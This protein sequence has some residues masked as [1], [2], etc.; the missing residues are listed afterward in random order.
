VA[1]LDEQEKLLR[2][3][4]DPFLAALGAFI[5]D[6]TQSKGDES[7]E[8]MASAKE[9]I[10][11]GYVISAYARPELALRSVHVSS[12]LTLAIAPGSG[13]TERRKAFEAAANDLHEWPN[14][15]LKEVKS[16]DDARGRCSE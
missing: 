6:S 13:E 2:E 5:V 14:A 8:A 9:L 10:K 7:P 12:A 1:R 11:A 15:F 3:K 4:S 16:V